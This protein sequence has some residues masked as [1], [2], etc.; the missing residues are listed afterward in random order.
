VKGT[1]RNDLK[2][3]W[4]DENLKIFEISLVEADIKR[5]RGESGIKFRHGNGG[6][7]IKTLFVHEKSSGKNGTNNF[8]W[9]KNVS[10]LKCDLI[11]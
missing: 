7:N 2:S 10:M 3:H 4:S 8:D 1:E 5:Q 11:L 9:K 6:T